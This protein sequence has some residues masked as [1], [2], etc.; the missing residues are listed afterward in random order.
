MALPPQ[1]S[2]HPDGLIGYT[3]FVGG[4]LRT[5]RSPAL[6]FN[7]ANVHEMRGKAFGRLWVSGA[8]AAKW[9]AN[10]DP[11][12]DARNIDALIGN[13]DSTDPGEVVLIST[14][15]VYPEP[16][17]VDEGVTVLPEEH[18]QAYGR[19]RL[20][21]ERFV[22]ER[23][24]TA[25]VLRLPGLFGP[26]LKKNLI[27]D[28]AG[29]RGGQFVHHES[30]FQFYDLDRL[31]SDADKAV[32]LGLR[33]VNLATQPVGAQTLAQSVFGI[34]LT[35][36]SVPRVSYDMR[37]VHSAAFGVPEQAPYLQGADDVLAAIR[38]FAG[39]SP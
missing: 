33:T 10:A 36:T 30:V 26:G 13:L 2:H 21:L 35:G 27:F 4:N 24:T 14:V 34:D 12:G 31:A 16:H 17:G 32:E 20:R 15:D 18:D 1:A 8:P 6:C 5:Q 39:T 22:L 37:T 38:V 9:V 25:C 29:G 28:L 23:F 19:N 11:D 3:G 7:R